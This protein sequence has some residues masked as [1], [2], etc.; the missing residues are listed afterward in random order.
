MHQVDY[1]VI[2]L[3]L[4]LR[5]GVGL[6]LKI[7]PSFP[8]KDNWL[9]SLLWTR[10]FLW[11][12]CVTLA[13]SLYQSG[14]L[15]KPS[16][17]ILP[18]HPRPSGSESLFYYPVM[19]ESCLDHSK[20]SFA[21]WGHLGG[22]IMCYVR[23]YWGSFL[24]DP[25]ASVYD[26]QGRESLILPFLCSEACSIAYLTQNQSQCL[27]MGGPPSPEWSALLCLCGPHTN[28]LIVLATLW[29]TCQPTIP[30]LECSCTRGLASPLTSFRFLLKM[31]SS[32]GGLL[33]S[34]SAT[35]QTSCLFLAAF[36]SIDLIIFFP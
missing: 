24:H 28:L 11:P 30:C 4:K 20:K 10:P 3:H 22:T 18:G 7:K 5:S 2:N 32:Q 23:R 12:S 6:G 29:A 33:G 21:E 9:H 16:L 14:H 17:I 19:V 31:S 15:Y 36:C 13:R 1:N 35:L 26:L 8:G 25:S 34:L 27:L